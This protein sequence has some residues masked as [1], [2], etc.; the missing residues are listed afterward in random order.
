MDMPGV[1]NLAKYRKESDI[2]YKVAK[3]STS[4]GRAALNGDWHSFLGRLMHDS[5]LDGVVH[6]AAG[7]GQVE[8]LHKFFDMFPDE[9]WALILTFTHVVSIFIA[10]SCFIKQEVTEPHD[11]NYWHFMRLLRFVLVIHVRQVRS[12]HSSN[13]IQGGILPLQVAAAAK[14]EEVVCYLLEQGAE[15]DAVGGKDKRTALSLAI[16]GE[17][18]GVA[19][20]LM[21][22]GASLDLCKE[23]PGN[24]QQRMFNIKSFELFQV[25]WQ[26]LSLFRCFV[27]G[28]IKLIFCSMFVGRVQGQAGELQL[29]VP[30]RAR[31]HVRVAWA[32]KTRQVVAFPHR[33]SAEHSFY[34]R[35]E[36]RQEH[37]DADEVGGRIQKGSARECCQAQ[38]QGACEDADSMRNL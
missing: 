37:A 35:R 22:A 38:S 12:L 34:R 2:L 7:G 23:M 15:V 3:F 36:G 10:N 29:G 1:Q 17:H 19:T 5:N 30:R 28:N 18:V 27:N 32:A 24:L 20:V 25:C 6:C 4:T 16:Q 21:Q 14:Q 26:S 11:Q 8:F 13:I 31:A 33:V 9:V